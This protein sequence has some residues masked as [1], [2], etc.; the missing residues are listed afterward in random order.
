VNTTYQRLLH[1]ADRGA[2]SPGAAAPTSGAMG[3]ATARVN[4]VVIRRRGSGAVTPCSIAERMIS[5]GDAT[6][7]VVLL[8]R[9]P[10]RST[11]ACGCHLVSRGRTRGG[12]GHGAQ[13]RGPRYWFNVGQ[14]R[15]RMTKLIHYLTLLRGFEPFRP[16][17]AVSPCPRPPLTI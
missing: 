12:R 1:S 7:M 15:G 10:S 16:F 8:V 6:S 2:L 13:P 4:S 11:R 5:A 14:R 9:L 3:D 17:T